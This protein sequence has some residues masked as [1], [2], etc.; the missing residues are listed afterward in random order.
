M[1][2]KRFNL[3]FFIKILVII[4][5]VIFTI[6]ITRL[7]SGESCLGIKE[8]Y[9][10]SEAKILSEKIS[11]GLLLGMDLYGY[12]GLEDMAETLT[13]IEPSAVDAVITDN[14]GVPVDYTFEGERDEI[15]K[16]ALIFSHKV[17]EAMGEE[18]A[19]VSDGKNRILI[20]PFSL[21]EENGYVIVIYD[22]TVLSKLNGI[23]PVSEFGKTVDKVA[24]LTFETMKETASALYEKGLKPED[25][26][27]MSDYY[28]KSVDESEFISSVSFSFDP[29]PPDGFGMS[30]AVFTTEQGDFYAKLDINR[31]YVK[32]VYFYMS[33]TLLAAVI[34]CIM[35]VIEAGSLGKL[36]EAKISRNKN[37]GEAIAPALK[38]FTFFV[39]M[40]VFAALPY[41][42]VILRESSGG[43]FL[44]L[45]AAVV[46][47]LP[48]VLENIG[49][50]IMLAL[51]PK[52][53]GALGF[54]VYSKVMILAALAPSVLCA[55]FTN[56]LSVLIC[57]FFLGV[58][59]G[60]VKY[61]MN[62]IVGV[63]SDGD[64]E[65]RINFGYYNAGVLMGLTAGGSLGG[66]IGAAKGY[67]YVFMVSGGI[68][69]AFL[70]IMAAVMPYDYIQSKIKIRGN[71][72]TSD[73]GLGRLF[74]TA[75]KKPEIILNFIITC[76]PLNLGLMF[77]VAFL[78]VL[79]NVKNMSSIV[80]SYC[81][82]IYGIAGNCLGLWLIRASGK[83]RG[84][85]LAF[86][87]M[88]LICGSVLV[89]I[90]WISIVTLI[91]SALLA[92]LFDGF[93]SAA[94]TGVFINAGERAGAERT[95]LMTGSA[96]GG[97]IMGIVSPLIYGVVLESGSI[98]FNLWI[99]AAFF[100]LSALGILSVRCGE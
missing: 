81:Y 8:Q 49:V 3:S 94:V 59:I 91:V 30:E 65:V 97:S 31:D 34:L 63:C 89:L 83:V 28:S 24:E 76:V 51:A 41:G 71:E 58:C 70:L 75:C 38:V 17:T 62:Y 35:I 55:F 46:V 14:F 44:G 23:N 15:Y 86:F 74:K 42:A 78:P 19:V 1:R 22:K 45:P 16:L 39:Y 96:V 27:E 79:L 61:A 5:G 77:I 69:L 87:G 82:L 20:E 66:I 85:L 4:C 2:N 68:L 9:L 67:S 60:M 52:F 92:G 93:G 37:D 36:F 100:M 72:T 73:A 98:G 48:V 40:A 95:V 80:S 47:S 33:L 32:R 18:T 7:Q 57:S 25:I 53:F 13:S 11:T 26:A 56:A 50:F 29:T 10:R 88:L 99:V 54:R 90:P 6:V 43:G 21:G 64:D 12:Y 84:K